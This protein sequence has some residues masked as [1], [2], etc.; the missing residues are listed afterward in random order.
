VEMPGER[1]IWCYNCWWI[2]SKHRSIQHL[3]TVPL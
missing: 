2:D 3:G 1:D